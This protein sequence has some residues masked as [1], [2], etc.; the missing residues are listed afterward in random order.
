[1]V[2]SFVRAVRNAL[3]LFHRSSIGDPQP[4]SLASK[5]RWLPLKGIAAL[6]LAFVVLGP[7]A[8]QN[9]YYYF[10]GAASWTALDATPAF[11]TL[12]A[13]AVTPADS[14][15]ALGVSGTSTDGL[16]RDYSSNAQICPSG[17]RPRSPEIKEL[18]RA[19]R[20]G[21]GLT[22]RPVAEIGEHVDLVYEYVRNAV[23]TEFQFGMTKG[24]LGVIID[25]NGTPFDQAKLMVEV[26]R[27]SGVSVRYK[28]GD[29]TLNGTQFAEWTGIT[30]AKA[31]CRFLASGGIP[32][33]VN[34][35]SGACTQS[36][37]VS[38]VVMAHVWVEADIGGQSY[39]FDPSFKPYTHLA[40]VDVRAISG[41]QAGAAATTTAQ[42]VTRTNSGATTKNYNASGLASSLETQTQ[43]LRTWMNETDHRG[44]GVDDIVGGRRILPATRP[45]G[46]W[47]QTSLPYVST[48]RA[49][50]T[51]GV[52]D[53][54]RTRF[55]LD[56][57]VYGEAAPTVQGAFFVDEIYG[58]RLEVQKY[59]PSTLYMRLSFDGVPL[60][61]VPAPSA[62]NQTDTGVITINRPFAANGSG[63]GDS[64]SRHQ[65]TSADAVEIVHAWG[66]TSSELSAKWEREAPLDTWFDQITTLGSI[67]R[68][69]LGAD[70]QAQFTAAAELHGELAEARVTQLSTVGI[71]HGISNQL[72]WGQG[73]WEERTDFANVIDLQTSIAVTSR[74]SDVASRRALI[75]ALAATAA[76]LEG[77][78]GEQATDSPTSVST[79][80]RIAWSN[81]PSLDLGTTGN[82]PTFSTFTGAASVPS[83]A[84]TN[85]NI[86]YDYATV[87]RGAL[88]AYANKGFAITTATEAVGGF[89]D[90]DGMTAPFLFAPQSLPT[91]QRGGAFV[92]TKYDA[93]GD[94]VE[95]AHVV[96]GYYTTAKGGGVSPPTGGAPD[97]A[98]TLKDQFVDRSSALG[99]N[100]SSGQTGFT[101]AALQSVGAG[102]FPY[103]LEET[104]QMRGESIVGSDPVYPQPIDPTRISSGLVS[105]FDGAAVIGGAGLSAMT[106]RPDAAAPTIVAFVAMQDVYSGAASSDRDVVGLLVA[107][108]WGRKLISNI[109]TIF[110]GGAAEQYVRTGTEDG[111]ALFRAPTGTARVLM[112]GNRRRISTVYNSAQEGTNSPEQRYVDDQLDFTAYDGSGNRRTY[113]YWAGEYYPNINTRGHRSGFR[114][115]TMTYASGVVV[116]LNYPAM[117]LPNPGANY[118]PAPMVPISVSSNLGL[119]LTLSTVPAVRLLQGGPA[120]L[121]PIGFT[122]AANQLSA[123]YFRPSVAR[124]LTTRPDGR[125]RI[126]E[127][128]TPAV[129]GSATTQYTYDSVN[130]IKEARDAIAVATPTARGAHQFFIAEGYR[131]E[132]QDPTGGRYAVETLEAG[133][134]S[135][136]IDEEGRI[137]TSASDGRGRVIRRTTAYGNITEFGYDDRDNTIQVKRLPRAGCGTDT[138]YWCQ[139]SIVTATYNSWNKPATI[140][141]PATVPDGQAAH[142]WT[143]TYNAQG[144]LTA[145]T[146]PS[147][148]GGPAVWR[149]DYDSYGRVLWTKDPTEVKTRFEYGG[150]GQ[151]AWCMTRQHAVDQNAALRQTTQ[152]TCNA[153]GDVLSTTD[154]LGNTTTYTRDLMH[155]KVGEFGP[156]STTML[157]TWEYDG[158]GNVTKLTRFGPTGGMVTETAYSLTG[159][160][161]TVTDPS[162]DVARTCYDAMDRPIVSVDPTGRATATEY[163]KAGQVRFVKRWYT[164]S[165][166]DATCALTQARPAHLTTN[167]WRELRY[168]TG[169]LQSAE[170]DGNG[171]LTTMTYDGLGRPMLTTFADGKY[172]Q[173]LRNERDQV[174]ITFKRGGDVHQAYYDALGRAYRV[175]EHDAASAGHPYPYG[176]HTSTAYD[177]AG[178]PLTMQVSTQ[179]AMNGVYDT[180]LERDIRTYVYDDAGRVTQD[181]FKP[182]D[183]AMGSNQL[184][185]TY[186]YD[187]NNNRTSIEWPDAYR[188]TYRYDAVNR[189]DRIQF[190]TAAAPT[191]NQA[192]IAYDRLS[193]RTTL[194]RSNGVVSTWTYEDDDDLSGINHAWASGSAQAPA[195]YG[196]QRDAG[197]RITMADINRADLE[198]MP[199]AAEARTYGTPNNLNQLPSANGV[200]M[201]WDTNGNLDAYGTTDYVWTWGNRLAEVHTPT[202]DT[203]YAYDAQDRRT[204]VKEDNV[205]TRTLWSGDDEVGDYADNGTVLRRYIPDGSGAMDARLA[206]VDG[207]NAVVWFHTDHQGSVIATTNGA[208]QPIQFANYSPQGKFGTDQNGLTYTSTVS[209]SPFGYTGRKWDAKAGLY[210]YRARYYS[211]ELGIFLSHDPIGTKDDPNLYTYVG[212]DPV[213]L[214]D[215]MGLCAMRDNQVE[216]CNIV[217]DKSL[218]AEV[219]QQYSE[220]LA[221]YGSAIE[222]SDDAEMKAAWAAVTDV[223]F[224][225]GLAGGEEGFATVRAGANKATETVVLISIVIDINTD[226]NRSFDLVGSPSTL[227]RNAF[228]TTFFHEVGHGTKDAVL[229]SLYPTLDGPSLKET[230]AEQRGVGL[231]IETGIL[232]RNTAM[233]NYHTGGTGFSVAP[234]MCMLVGCA[235]GSGRD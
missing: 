66:D 57:T 138:L 112:G 103:K 221:R 34:G 68:A 190:G 153:A 152:F 94:P 43:T 13:D 225:P 182:N 81:D 125:G 199:T 133:R 36:G 71:V 76:T 69:K 85:D 113:E 118:Y 215:P 32:A 136:H 192:D 188:A 67:A 185:L 91:N 142:T 5:R 162:G 90:R 6:V 108:W 140:T 29:I 134:Q 222:G 120:S 201:T 20:G 101:S 230:Y 56:V 111:K 89:G 116:T 128:W 44:L 184:V 174:Y 180:A 31:A 61:E 163:N 159:Q 65:F 12:S 123:I 187:A 60:A 220:E 35:T 37:V 218:S 93:N 105:N 200:S 164:A 202:S 11:K 21:P 87:L 179:T 45:T 219:Q 4:S 19:L 80:R 95:I 183:T 24:E 146:S 141:L 49:T 62:W 168:N 40:G 223:N 208:G 177:L 210:N 175:W 42:G 30:D 154:P 158:A 83:L 196:F 195:V 58:R 129:S 27:E 130:R 26:L 23:D 82:S 77:S 110:Q 149:T 63:Y 193:R 203:F 18:A 213:N 39:Q 104:L 157:T 181:R 52:P 139:T 14:A 176:R 7:A 172:I 207:A 126:A 205:V 84:I 99:V 79:A 3:G 217:F 15:T 55:N 155:R 48:L 226:Y 156:S 169:G 132:R 173:T 224:G 229:S 170:L 204:W 165:T 135:R 109:V 233:R 131:G 107:D 51:G 127:I 8:A 78:V 171:N 194:T 216:N 186:G 25:K 144:L 97:P 50:W 209:G 115:K 88:T 41:F 47:R 92:A 206:V 124:S 191:A 70:W 214:S 211:P 151:N 145:Q 160:A 2:S 100:L 53:N 167:T 161:L 72:A 231:A 75:H 46:G 189:V 106:G 212:L 119:S 17:S 198:W 150:Y 197:G 73:Y 64:V 147:I 54:Y 33:I 121:N 102:E 143:F 234:S 1:M 96:T 16:C 74:N 232:P 227:N 122:N 137:A 178:R 117:S 98:Q 10:F 22:S 228:A 86:H 114:L 38:S 9:P 148:T 59:Y 235:G 166:S 28:F